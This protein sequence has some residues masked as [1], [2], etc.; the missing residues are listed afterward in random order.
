MKHLFG[1]DKAIPPLASARLQ[2]W[3]LIL[4]AYQYRI[5]HKPGKENS[6]ADVLSRLPLPECPSEVPLPGAR[7]LL[8]ET[9][10]TSPV[11]AKQIPEWTER[12]P[13]LSKVKKWLTEG[14]PEKEREEEL[15][16]YRQRKEELSLQDGCILWGQRVIPEPGHKLVVEELHAGHQDISRMKSLARSFV[17]WPKLDA[18]LEDRAKRCEI[19]QVHLKVPAPA[20]LHPWEWPVTPWCRLHLDHAGPFQGKMI[21]DSDAAVRP[22][23]V[24][25]VKLGDRLA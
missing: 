11:N 8:L 9:L 7:V 23:T 25:T 14:W 21:I 20:P 16:P 2:R 22:P 4:S 13:I 1:E 17:W 24:K 5:V 3:A 19:C 18:D 12:D 6:K 15:R 10:E